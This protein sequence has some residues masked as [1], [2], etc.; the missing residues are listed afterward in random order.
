M[1]DTKRV[2]ITG[3]K[4]NIMYLV[5]KS[6]T[7]LWKNIGK[8]SLINNC[9]S[10]RTIKLFGQQDFVPN[11]VNHFFQT[12]LM[13][14]VDLFRC[15]W[16]NKK[17]EMYWR[18]VFRSQGTQTKK[19]DIFD[20]RLQLEKFPTRQS[21]TNL[22]RHYRQSLWDQFEK[23]IKNIKNYFQSIFVFLTLKRR[24]SIPSSV[25]DRNY[26]KPQQNSEKLG[27][28]TVALFDVPKNIQQN[29]T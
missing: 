26:D 1:L 12:L 24:V 18:M 11:N 22:Y 29:W 8:I 19:Q 17:K 16:V 23:V 21:K 9:E 14:L 6:I 25:L 13:Y 4:Y 2:W 15:C 28:C 10:F 20:G 27:L 7:N 5:E 3:S